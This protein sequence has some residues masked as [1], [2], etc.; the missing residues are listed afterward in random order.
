MKAATTV[1]DELDVKV[2]VSVNSAGRHAIT[3][4]REPV[5][6]KR[7][8]TRKGKKDDK[9]HERKSEREVME[10]NDVYGERLTRWQDESSYEE[11]GGE[12]VKERVIDVGQ[13]S[14][15]RQPA[16]AS[17]FW[18]AVQR[19]NHPRAARNPTCRDLRR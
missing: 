2:S 14:T 11:G 5:I 16:V 8:K 1:R 3:K 17:G 12:V 18:N 6:M 19:S 15:T 10:C 9:Y 7:K 4:L 13:A